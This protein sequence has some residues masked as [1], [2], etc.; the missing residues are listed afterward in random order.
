MADKFNGLL[1]ESPGLV[2]PE[3]YAYCCSLF[4]YDHDAHYRMILYNLKYRG[5]VE[6]G[7]HFGR[8]LGMRIAESAHFRDVDCV[9]PVPLHWRRRWKRGY[10]QAEVIASAMAGALGVTMRT[11]V[12]KRRR[13]TKTQTQLDIEAKSANVSGAFEVCRSDVGNVK[14]LLIVD[15]LFTTGSTLMA[16]F[17][18]LRKAFPYPVRIS[19]ATLGFVGR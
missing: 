10:N 6:V 5:N 11:D 12:L 7:E 17:A 19:V 2:T 9:I 13:Y 15:D 18:A 3:H 16:C 1:Q 8:M 4:F 14:H